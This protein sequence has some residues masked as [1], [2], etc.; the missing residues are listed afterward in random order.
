MDIR[1][2]DQGSN[3]LSAK[4]QTTALQNMQSQIANVK[5]TKDLEANDA[6]SDHVQLSHR[7]HTHEHGE[8]VHSS[9]ETTQQQHLE[10][11]QNSGELAD[12]TDGFRDDDAE[13][14][15]RRRANDEAEQ[16]FLLTG[17]APFSRLMG[18]EASD[19]LKIDTGIS[20]RDLI[21]RVHADV[22]DEIYEAAG[23]FVKS[24]MATETRPNQSLTQLKSIAEP[25]RI[26]TAKEEF[27]PMLDIHDSHNHPMPL[28]E[29]AA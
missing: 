28:I 16:A 14:L 9:D 3:P 18:V 2:F 17:N 25:G 22:P 24:Q 10:S 1:S 13:A 29:D 15:D 11:A 12:L 6:P 7:L 26:E 27:V 19:D 4:F 5:N 21:N 23:Q 20:E 8:A